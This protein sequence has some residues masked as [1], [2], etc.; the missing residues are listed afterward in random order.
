M[1]LSVL[2]SMPQEQINIVIALA[3]SFVL[4]K[5]V[6]I[7]IFPW[8]SCRR[9]KSGGGK[10]WD[11]SKSNFRDCRRCGGEGRQLRLGRSV[12]NRARGRRRRVPSIKDL[13]D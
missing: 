11:W 2:T 12:W 8:T 3:A 4:Y 6:M 1:D 7:T 10:L 13:W 5:L 9:C